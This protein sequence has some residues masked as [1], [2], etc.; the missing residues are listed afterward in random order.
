[1]TTHWRIGKFVL[2]LYVVF[3]LA[4]WIAYQFPSSPDII[5]KSGETL[6]EYHIHQNLPEYNR[7]TPLSELSEPLETLATFTDNLTISE[8]SI[9]TDQNLLTENTDN[10]SEL[11]ISPTTTSSF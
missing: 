4:L 10:L 1:M 3:Q 9:L 6:L 11:E 8:P 5:R 7:E 2:G